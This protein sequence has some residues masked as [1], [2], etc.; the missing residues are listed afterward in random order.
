MNREID[1][2]IDGWVDR[3]MG[4]KTDGWIDR[5]MKGQTSIHRWMSGQTLGW[6]DMQKDRQF[7]QTVR[8][9]LIDRFIFE[10]LAHAL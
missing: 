4:R 9:T 3:Q 5:Q 8:L 2:W 1:R 7:N 10:H 6:I